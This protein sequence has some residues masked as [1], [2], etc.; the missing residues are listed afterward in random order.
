MGGRLCGAAVAC[1]P[2][3]SPAKLPVPAELAPGDG[4][5]ATGDGYFLPLVGGVAQCKCG[6]QRD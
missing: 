3:S 2:G 4:G 1:N 6:K 5:I